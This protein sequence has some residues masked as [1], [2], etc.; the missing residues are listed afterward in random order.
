MLKW[1][2]VVAIATACTGED[3]EEW[4]GG[5]EAG[6]SWHLTLGAGVPL[7]MGTVTCPTIAA[8]RIDLPSNSCSS[9]CGSGEGCALTFNIDDAGDVIDDESVTT[10]FTDDCIGA[11]LSCTGGDVEN[12][13]KMSCGFTAAPDC[14]YT[15]QLV[16]VH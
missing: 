3:A 16:R 4:Y 5:A 10:D 12:D 9:A 1:L 2:A 7:L 11:A 15:G 6:S 13:P 8:I 14:N